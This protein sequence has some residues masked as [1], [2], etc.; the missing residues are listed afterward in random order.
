[1][2]EILSNGSK[3]FGELPD[4]LETLL[5][6]LSKYPLDPV[7]EDYGDFVN[8]NPEWLSPEV[9]EKYKGC[10]LIAGNFMEISHVFRFVTDDIDLIE[11]FSNAINRNKQTTE[12][13]QHKQY[14]EERK[15]KQEKAR[16]LF[17]EGKITLKELYRY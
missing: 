7:F 15:L 5:D 6:A 13:K 11:K 3:W 14:Y 9:T 4:T 16:R 8:L 10:A 17:D 1:M 2:L 12:Y